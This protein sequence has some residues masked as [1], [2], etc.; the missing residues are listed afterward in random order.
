MAQYLNFLHRP[1]PRRHDTNNLQS[2]LSHS[3][4]RHPVAVKVSLKH[5]DT[6]RL[7]VRGFFG[8]RVSLESGREADMTWH[9]ADK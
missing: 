4:E 7:Y 3:L 9:V 8:M 1:N 6:D 5:E 2:Q